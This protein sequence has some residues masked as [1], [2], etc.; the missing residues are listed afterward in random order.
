M[1][2]GGKKRCPIFLIEEEPGINRRKSLD[3]YV[4]KN[5]IDVKKGT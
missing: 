5:N 3:T 1:N 2:K 4:K